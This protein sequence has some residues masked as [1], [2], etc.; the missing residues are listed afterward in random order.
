MASGYDA[1]RNRVEAAESVHDDIR[2]FAYG[3]EVDT[4]APEGVSLPSKGSANELV[5]ADVADDASRVV[6]AGLAGLMRMKDEGVNT[7]DPEAMVRHAWSLPEVHPSSAGGYMG[8]SSAEQTPTS[9]KSLQDL[10][11]D[12]VE[13]LK[14]KDAFKPFRSSNKL[15][16][17]SRPEKVFDALVSNR[18]EHF[19]EQLA[20]WYEGHHTGTTTPEGAPIYEEGGS[21]KIVNDAADAA[22]VDRALVRRATAMGSMKSVW[23]HTDKETKETRYP[24]AEGAAE[25]VRRSLS[26]P[27]MSVE[28]VSESS[29]ESDVVNA[30]LGPRRVL[31]SEMAR[32]EHS[33]PTEPIKAGKGKAVAT[34]KQSNF[35]LG[36]VSP[37]HPVY[38]YGSWVAAEKSKAFTSDTHDLKAAGIKTPATPVLD[39]QGKPKVN[40]KG[41]VVK[42]NAGEKWIANPSGYDIS[43]GSAVVMLA[44]QF[45][46]NLASVRESEGEE[47]AT[48]WARKNAHVYTPNNAQADM[49]VN[50]RGRE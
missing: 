49:W 44:E 33:A 16:S 40:S 4:R 8:W 43:R 17:R 39:E 13:E 15:S 9:K 18:A 3:K 37:H 20:P 12:R 35:D 10:H 32:G 47:A 11:N 28:D 50:V 1:I 34:A 31:I 42:H 46:K 22:G 36:L 2:R 19:S 21:V 48:N 27:H 30:V 45:S 7:A 6:G 26:F 24:N 41:E 5:H 38:G 29:G 25:Q 14:T 23:S